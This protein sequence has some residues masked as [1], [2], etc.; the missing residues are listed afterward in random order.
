M[1]GKPSRRARRKL[2]QDGIHAPA[3]VL[4]IAGRG[5]AITHG[6]EA[7]VSNTELALKLRLRVEPPGQLPF[8]VECKLRFPQLAVPPVG[9]RIAVVY[10]PDDPETIMLDAS[11]AGMLA[12]ANLRPDQIA[13]IEAARELASAGASPEAIM[14]RV[15]EIRAQAGVPPAQVLGAPPDPIDQLTKLAELRDRGVLTDAEFQAQK[16]RILGG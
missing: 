9:G 7:I 11:P 3:T 1:L 15:N 5:M 13:S 8:E 12:G 14:A 10:D 16:A 2:E 4:E 6:S